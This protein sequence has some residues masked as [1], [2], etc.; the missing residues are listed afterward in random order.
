VMRCRSRVCVQAE[1]M[2]FIQNLFCFSAVSP[3]FSFYLWGHVS[4]R[5][6]I[7]RHHIFC[8]LITSR[9]YSRPSYHST[10][11]CSPILS[12]SVHAITSLEQLLVKHLSSCVTTYIFPFLL[13]Y[14]V[15]T[16]QL[17]LVLALHSTHLHLFTLTRLTGEHLCTADRNPKFSSEDQSKAFFCALI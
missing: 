16:T 1:R 12:A 9:H 13:I 17:F 5:I 2:P 10:I 11:H 7:T 14:R 8:F 6:I 4:T 15:Y 3:A